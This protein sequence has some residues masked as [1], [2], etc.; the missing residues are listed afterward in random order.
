VKVTLNY[1]L[2][3]SKNPVKVS[4]SIAAS[5][6]A[7]RNSALTLETAMDT[8]SAQL[9]DR[10]S[11]L[12]Q[13]NALLKSHLQ[14]CER[15]YA[16]LQ[17]EVAEHRQ[18]QQDEPV[19]QLMAEQVMV[20]TS[21]GHRLLE[22]TAQAAN[23]LLTIADF[24][25]AVNT[26]LQILGEALETDRLA[27]HENFDDAIDPSFKCWRTLYN[28]NSLNTVAQVAHP[29]A[30][31]GNYKS[32]RKWYVRLKQGRP[33]SYRIE[34]APEP[35]RSGQIAI[36]V[37]S[38][39]LIPIHVEGEFWGVLGLDDCCKAKHRSAAE[40]SVLKIAT[41]CIGS[42]I[43]R[44]RTHQK[45][46]EVEQARTRSAAKHSQELQRHNAELQQTLD[47]LSESEKR[48]RT[49]FEISNEGICH[50]EFEQPISTLLPLSE[51]VELAYRTNRLTEVNQAF[52]QQYG[53]DSP[54]AIVGTRISDFYVE[55]SQKNTQTNEELLSNFQIR[56]LETEEVDQ[57]GNR[58]YFLSSVVCTLQGDEIV[59]G[60]GIQTDITELR[61]TQQALLEAEQARVAE[62]SKV[63]EELQQRD[64][65]LQRSY[66]LLATVAEVTK[67]LLENPHVEEA[68]AQALRRIGEAADISRVALMFEQQNDRNGQLHHQVIYEWVAPNIPKQMHDPATAVVHN[69]DYGC[70][71]DELHAGRSIWLMIEDIPEPARTQQAQIGV[72]STGAVPIFIEGKYFGC[73]GFDDCTNYRQWTPHEIDVLTSGAGAIGAALHRQ[74]LVDRLIKERI[75]AEQARSQELAKANEALKRSLD[76][77]AS[78]PSLDKFLG[79][80]LKVIAEQLDAPLTEYWHH[81]EP[82]NIAYVGLTYW[83]GQILRPEEQLGHIGAF[84][85][86]V[87]PEMI[88]Q[89]SLHHRRSHFITDDIATSEVHVQI[90]RDYGLDAGAWYEPHGVS[91]LLNVPMMYPE[92]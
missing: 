80:V 21:L 4:A 32:I 50:F 83:Q 42:A 66:C 85:Y 90:T 31:Q 1:G 36:G 39:A 25:A 52:A 47:R 49:L 29:E 56:N 87:P 12:E 70:L 73:V 16:V 23:A 30:G 59:G 79:Q 74:Q 33:I 13:E 61:E 44:Q 18:R 19:Q 2:S 24:D 68:I 38:T 81:P 54:A 34:D 78:E 41:D 45:L 43:Q 9:H 91:R 82:H 20:N 10:L 71:V 72:N 6:Y 63:N 86:P 69:D 15:S 35:F 48:Y 7:T 27:I 89:E 40:L 92:N 22:A 8:A 88:H 46:L 5:L 77:L 3:L 60:W 37:K 64:R 53:L 58:R 76:S 28:W 84:G 75:Q 65:Q 57:F 26:A 55:D 14:S 51:R 11:T 17:A 62:L 67:N